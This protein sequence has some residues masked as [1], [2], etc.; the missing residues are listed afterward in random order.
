MNAR[1]LFSPALLITFILLASSAAGFP[2]V[3]NALQLHL[4]KKPIEPRS[5][6]RVSSV[7]KDFGRWTPA[8]PDSLLSKEMAQELGTSNY[9]SRWYRS[10]SEAEDTPQSFQLHLAYY[11]G[12]IDTVPHVPERC[13]V[14]GGMVQDGNT[15]GDLRVN[16]PLDPP[17][18]IVNNNAD[19]IL[20]EGTVYAARSSQTFSR[21]NLPVG[22]ENLR[23]TATPFET[24]EGQKV[25]AGY[26]FIANGRVVS[27]ADQVRLAAFKLSDDYSYYAKIQFLSFDVQNAQEL[28]DL[29]AEV[30][31]DIFP[32]IMRAMP[33]WVEVR[34]GAYP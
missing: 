16:Y 28:A 7:P 6:L 19:P 13:F 22:V 20:M 17:N 27:S 15:I 25:W 8:G 29:A 11:T 30:L 21:V 34:E 10:T 2:T 33:D 24:A 3:L 5:G 18:V 9:L 12:G 31:S 1:F 23:M 26:F 32:E 4:E 14:G